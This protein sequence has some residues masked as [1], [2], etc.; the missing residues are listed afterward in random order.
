ALAVDPRSVILGGGVAHLGEPLRAAVADALRAQAA[1][2]PFL[3]SL[4]LAERLR[5]VPP[6]VPVAALGAAMVGR[7]AERGGR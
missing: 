5:L 7:R 1:S 2:S 4:D 3:A 6:D